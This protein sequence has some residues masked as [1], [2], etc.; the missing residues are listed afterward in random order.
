MDELSP[1]EKLVVQAM[2][3][4]GATKEEKKKTADDIAKIKIFFFIVQNKILATEDSKMLHI[5]FLTS[6]KLIWSLLQ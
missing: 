5:R 4:L 3:E 2:E 6:E 1:I